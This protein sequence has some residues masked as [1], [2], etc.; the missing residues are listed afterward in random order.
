MGEGGDVEDYD[1]RGLFSGGRRAQLHAI[2]VMNY[3]L[4]RWVHLATDS[5]AASCR[6]LPRVYDKFTTIR[7]RLQHHPTHRRRLTAST[8]AR[9]LLVVC[10]VCIS[11]CK[12]ISSLRLIWSNGI[13]NYVLSDKQNLSNL[14]LHDVLCTL[15][16]VVQLFCIS[17]AVLFLVCLCA[18]YTVIKVAYLITAS[19]ID[20]YPVKGRLCGVST[21]VE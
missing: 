20:K 3:R 5:A 14:F 21:E 2:D 6:L 18:C 1:G 13:H 7:P 10:V 12:V 15:F 4:A 11:H 9:L 19:V 17:T 8:V 16:W